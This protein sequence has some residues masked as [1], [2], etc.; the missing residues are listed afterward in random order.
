VREAFAEAFVTPAG[1][2]VS[3]AQTAY[4]LALEWDLLPMEA[5]RRVAGR[6]LA[7]LVRA[8]GFRIGTGFVGTPLIC[9]A[10]TSTGISM[11]PV[12]YCCKRS[13]RL[14]LP[15]DHG[16]HHGVGALGQH[17]PGRQHQP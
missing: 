13:A 17:A 15:R 10:L 5:Q 6:R 4:A 14:A 12:G 7:D 11:W 2:V 8:S 16:R 9:D 3:D 1:R